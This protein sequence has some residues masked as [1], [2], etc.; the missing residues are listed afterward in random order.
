[1]KGQS[2]PLELTVITVGSILLLTSSVVLFDTIT[3]TY[4]QSVQDY[5]MEKAMTKTATALYQINSIDQAASITYTTPNRRKQDKE[6]R[7]SSTPNDIVIQ[8]N[9]RNKTKYKPEIAKNV[10]GDS[11]QKYTTVTKSTNNAM[12]ITGQ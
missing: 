2:L 5:H 6:Y 12:V 10:E 4:D 3:S 1:M 9:N 8:T 11:S 7:I